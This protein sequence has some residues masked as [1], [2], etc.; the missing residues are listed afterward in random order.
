MKSLGFGFQLVVEQ[1]ASRLSFTRV[2]GLLRS[3][4]S[5]LRILSVMG[6]QCAWS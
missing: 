6:A 3:D 4:Q 5:M 2:C 1:A